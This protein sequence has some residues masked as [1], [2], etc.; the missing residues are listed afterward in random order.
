M[1]SFP[2]HLL[3]DFDST[4][5]R[6]E[7]LDEL[8]RF[9]LR[10]HPE[11]QHRLKMFEALT[12]AGMDGEILFDESLSQRIALID[13]DRMDVQKI[14]KRLINDITPSFK[15]NK[16]YIHTFRKKIWIISGGFHEIIYPVVAPFGISPSRVIANHF[17]YD[18]NQKIIGF[19]SNNL[20]S[21]A[22]GK[23]RQLDEMN[24]E[25]TIHIIGDGYTDYEL[26]AKG[27]ANQFFAFIENIKR[28]NVCGL[29]DQVLESFD[30]YIQTVGD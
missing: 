28:E 24:L 15:R 16:N 11:K 19:D 10:K 4:F 25:G 7:S 1:L 13:A 26:K 18:E 23:V 2:D 5:I 14:S 8:A 9:S 20:M 21:K 12:H 30:K 22:E 29:A 27:T 3:I 6:K 17:L